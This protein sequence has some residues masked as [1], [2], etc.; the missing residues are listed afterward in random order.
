MYDL[1]IA[2]NTANKYTTVYINYPDYEVKA[3]IK[4]KILSQTVSDTVSIYWYK[5]NRI[6]KT[7]GGFEGKLLHGQYHSFYL[8]GNLKEQGQFKNGVKNG[9]WT[10]WYENGMFKAT[11]NWKLG[12]M[13]GVQKEFNNKGQLIKEIN[14]RRGRL[15]GK[16]VEYSDSKII[17]EKKYKNNIEILKKEK[18]VEQKKEKK[19][20]VFKEFSQK[21]ESKL[22]NLFKR[23]K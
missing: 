8:N 15:N 20:S 12:L 5:S 7:Q 14:Y 21:M 1:A 18:I 10:Q 23:K 17:S 13:S 6:H 11:I 4:N 3:R 16:T 9:K 19:N 2:Q 22:N